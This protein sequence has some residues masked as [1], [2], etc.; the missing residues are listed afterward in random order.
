M[1]RHPEGATFASPITQDQLDAVVQAMTR[2]FTELQQETRE[3]RSAN[4]EL[5]QLV[6]TKQTFC[7]SSENGGNDALPDGNREQ[8]VTFE[9]KSPLFQTKVDDRSTQGLDAISVCEADRKNVNCQIITSAGRFMS[10]QLHIFV[11]WLNDDY[12]C[13]IL[14]FV[15]SALHN[16]SVLT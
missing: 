5:R 16:V 9:Q 11:D 10:F 1:K 15:L 4:E 7:I 3:L 14:F 13:C 2:R 6:A 12:V 8:R